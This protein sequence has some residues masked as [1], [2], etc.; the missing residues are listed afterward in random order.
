MRRKQKATRR[1]AWLENLFAFRGRLLVRR[2][3]DGGG[4]GR[5]RRTTELRGR[6][7]GLR[8]KLREA[9]V[10]F[11]HARDEL[12]LDLLAIAAVH[13]AEAGGVADDV[14][15]EREQARD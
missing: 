5:A 4:F 12:L 2:G 13:D 9:L 14:G 7:R 3:R 10:D 6:L 1:R 11:G 15:R 8:L